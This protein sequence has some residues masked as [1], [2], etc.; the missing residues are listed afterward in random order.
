M[1]LRLKSL[2]IL[3]MKISY[4]W[5]KETVD[6]P[7]GPDQLAEDLTNCGLV[8]ETV[9]VESSDTIL[10]LDLTTNRPDCL[11]H[12]GVAREVSTL[13]QS[14]LRKS[15]VK[16]EEFQPVDPSQV[17]VRID[18]PQLCR[19]YAAR[20]IQGVRV[21]S[22][23]D[24]LRERLNSLGI[25]PLN[26]IVDVTNY[27][28]ME[29][30]HPTHAFDL[31]KIQ[32]AQ[33]LVR[34]AQTG[35]KLL[36][37]DGIQRHLESGM[38]LI[39]DPVKPLALAGIMGG[40]ESE[41]SV[42]TGDV[43]VESAWFDPISVRKTAK[44]LGLHTEASHRFERGANVEAIL[45]A[46]DRVAQL[47]QQLAGGKILG[48]MI[49]QYPQPLRRNSIL[50][51]RAR[52]T[53]LIGLE[54]D[55]QEVERILNF[56]EFTVLKSLKEGWTV[57]LPTS[58][59]DVEREIDLIEEVARHYGYGNLPPTL[60][61]WRSGAHRGPDQLAEKIVTDKLV[62]LGYSETLTSP[63][64]DEK[65]NRRFSSNSGVALLNPL[66]SE[67]GVMR[68][69]L[70]PGLLASLSWN[71][72]RSIRSIRLFEIG[73]VYCWAD[74]GKPREELRLAMLVSGNL[75]DKSIHASSQPFTLF[76]VKGDIQVLLGSLSILS[77]AVRFKVGGTGVNYWHPGVAGEIWLEQTQL[78]FLGQ[79]HPAI[80]EEYKVRQPVYIA[81]VWL[82]VLC[83]FWKVTPKMRKIPRFPSI[84]RD[85]S[86]LVDQAV[87][88]AEIE[89]AIWGTGIQE[90]SQVLPFDLYQ[91]DQIP[92]GKKGISVTLVYQRLDRTLVE[93][94][95]TCY[96][97]RV[98]AHLR[99]KLGAELRS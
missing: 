68:T 37:L 56:L 59:M 84:H 34:K 98:I 36:T 17:S 47:I 77:Q 54:I 96:Q 9:D 67:T 1:V 95:A 60:P 18:S 78:G 24:W 58:R 22:S 8:V 12:L 23:P 89:S 40:Q 61:S 70:I 93:A 65:D 99:D 80:C 26:N 79:L 53:Q 3:T 62:N 28:L 20:V 46:I 44:V 87:A 69:S 49:D 88:Y 97:E 15:V 63:F 19:R 33:I 32:N 7:V 11:S 91:G 25:R 72:N 90:L 85:L 38:L 74:P 82:S 30:G 50:L 73:K 55:S 29:I 51:R 83:S 21:G 5:L 39:T 64:V 48:S 41:I 45:P 92:S 71:Y 35:E 52:L 57:S 42:G 10:E 94:E 4:R 75:Q 16:V 76:D 13:Y 43:L 2:S 6:I 27:V 86:I 81:E 31:A 66:S 14:P